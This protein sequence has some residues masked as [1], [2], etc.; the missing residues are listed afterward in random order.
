VGLFKCCCGCCTDITASL[1]VITIAGY[2]GGEWTSVTDCCKKKLFTPNTSSNSTACG[3]LSTQTWTQQCVRKAWAYN[4]PKRA[5]TG[6]ASCPPDPS[7]YCYPSTPLVHVGTVTIDFFLQHGFG[8]KVF[9]STPK[10]EVLFGR[11]EFT[12]SGVKSCKWFLKT[13]LIYTVDASYITSTAYTQTRTT[14]SAHSCFT[15]DTS[16]DGTASSDNYPIPSVCEPSWFACGSMPTNYIIFERIKIWDSLPADGEFTFNNSDTGSSCEEKPSCADGTFDVA[17]ACISPQDLDCN[18]C[19]QPYTIVNNP[20]TFSIPSIEIRTA[21]TINGC[22]LDDCT[23]GILNCNSNPTTCPAVSQTLPCQK[24]VFYGDVSNYCACTLQFVSD[25]FA[26]TV[27]SPPPVCNTSI[28]DPGNY[29]IPLECGF[30]NGLIQGLNPF[31]FTGCST[32]NCNTTCC[33]K[34]GCGDCIICNPKLG[35]P[36]VVGSQEVSVSTTCSAYND[37]PITPTCITA[38]P[39]VLTVDFV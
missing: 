25:P 8:F 28:P 35:G 23:Q 22:D 12:C 31:A 34:I 18:P 38:S 16:N 1:P 21:T 2:T 26:A 39:V 9:Y 27:G 13:R 37:P 14:A 10:I 33:H 30:F 19:W 24:V 17:E 4:L 36:L 20:T 6:T 15:A 11:G 32:G 29:G 7:I 3:L 5:Q